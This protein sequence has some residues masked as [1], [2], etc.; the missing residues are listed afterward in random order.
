MSSLEEKINVTLSIEKLRNSEL[1]LHRIPLMGENEI[2][3][4][5]REGK[6]DEINIS[7]FDKIAPNLGFFSLPLQ[8]QCLYLAITGIAIY[9]R[10]AISAGA[11]PDDTFDLSD[12]MLYSLSELEKPEDI[13]EIYRIAPVMFAKLVAK[14]DVNTH[15]YQLNRILAYISNHIFKKITLKEVAEHTNLSPNYISALFVKEMN[16]S[17]HDY[18][19]KE[20]IYLSCNL[21][22]FSDRPISVISSYMGFQTQS[23]FGVIFKKWMHMTPAEYRKQYFSDVY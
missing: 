8:T 17:F 6:Y 3:R 20:K 18:I 14:L 5:I 16:I 21:L 22:K 1:E 15:S 10:E 19:Q 7:S 23:H 9:S 2:K 12:A 13:Y 11:N 4:K